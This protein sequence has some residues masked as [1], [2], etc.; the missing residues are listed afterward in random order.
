MSRISRSSSGG[1]VNIQDT[2]GSPITSTSG[3]LNVNVVGGTTA[4]Y[5]TYNQYGEQDNIAQNAEQTILTYTTPTT[6]IFYLTKIL[7]SSDSISQI[8]VQLNGTTLSIDRLGYGTYN[9]DFD[10]SFSIVPGINVPSSTTITVLGTNTS[11]NGP[12]TINATLIGVTQ[13]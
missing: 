12:S 13:T 9:G 10:Y 6:G 5:T 8:E 3:S 2:N 7:Y 4:V 1:S 11:P